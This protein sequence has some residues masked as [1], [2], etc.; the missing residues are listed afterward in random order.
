MHHVT[1]ILPQLHMRHE[2]THTH[3][4]SYL[5]S[6]TLITTGLHG[7]STRHYSWTH[8]AWWTG[9]TVWRTFNA[10]CV[11]ER[12]KCQ[13]Y[14]AAFWWNSI[15]WNCVLYDNHTL[16]VTVCSGILFQLIAVEPI[17]LKV[18]C[19][20]QNSAVA[21]LVVTSPLVWRDFL[22]TERERDFMCVCFATVLLVN[23]IS[24][25]VIDRSSMQSSGNPPVWFCWSQ[26][27]SYANARSLSHHCRHHVWVFVQL[28]SHAL[29]SKD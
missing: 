19:C 11:I 12:E 28:L 2:Q 15:L 21:V 24:T 3:K 4:C 1:G 5:K 25:A 26:S 20:W 6:L 23:C 29:P 16:N 18:C 9:G 22:C 7:W 8:K 10:M 13:M 14:H 27:S 17:V